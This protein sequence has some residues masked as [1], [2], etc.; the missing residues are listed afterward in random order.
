MDRIKGEKFSPELGEQ[1]NAH[2]SSLR[3]NAKKESDLEAALLRL[4]D[5]EAMLNSKDAAYTTALGEKRNLEAELKELKAQLAKV[6][7][8]RVRLS[9]TEF[10]RGLLRLL[11]SGKVHFL[12]RRGRNPRSAA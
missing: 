4:R 2:V 1:T 7:V 12:P 6:S 8:A 3:R 5:L 11:R 9:L 10:D